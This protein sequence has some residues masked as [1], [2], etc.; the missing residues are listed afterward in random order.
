MNRSL[1]LI[2]GAIGAAVVTAACGSN[3][4][5]GGGGAAATSTGSSAGATVSIGTSKVGKILVDGSGRTLYLFEADKGTTSTCYDSCV[6]VWPGLTTSGKP[7]AGA[8][9]ERA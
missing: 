2:A 5:G 1:L 6:Q 3:P 7:G 9:G 4:Y 8:G